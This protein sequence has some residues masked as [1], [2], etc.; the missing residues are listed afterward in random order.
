[1]LSSKGELLQALDRI[2]EIPVLVVGDII[3]D[4]YIWGSVER[5]SPEAPVPVV[6]VRRAEDRLGGAANVARNL[7]SIGAAV[8]LCGFIGDDEEGQVVL[9]LLEMEQVARDG[10]VVDR[11]RPTCLKTRVIAQAQQVVRVDRE[12]RVSLNDSLRQGFAAVVESQI[13]WAKAVVI[14][15]YGKGAVSEP[16]IGKFA[17]ARKSR[18]ISLT[19]RPLVVD[20]HP[21]NYAIY[22]EICIA[23]PNRK[24]AEIASGLQINNRESAVQAA[25]V[26]LQKW[27]AEM[28]MITLGEDGL[29]MMLADDAQPLF[30][31]T[32][33][34]EVYDVSGAGDTVTA[35]FSA[36]MGAGVKPSVAG[37]LA[38]IGAGVAVSEVGTVSVS[39]ERLC[40][41]IERVSADKHTA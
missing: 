39:R 27:N 36:A 22:R 33:A 15:D 29:L 11:Q 4:R 9:K 26:L 6:D 5:I 17:D 1:M 35:I 2:R 28:V 32:L 21:A 7:R 31:E 3:L 18:R 38:N 40:A 25:K 14:S 12:S 19:S 13:D 16:L 10:V 34:L 37:D 8:S 30:R 24:E 23:K 41:E 20:P